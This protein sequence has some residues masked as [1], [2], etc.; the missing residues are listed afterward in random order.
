MA[1]CVFSC[2]KLLSC[3][4]DIIKRYD[5]GKKGFVLEDLEK[6][7]LV[8]RFIIKNNQKNINRQKDLKLF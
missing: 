1:L 7:S 6:T 4:F 2:A 3:E 5:A 8:I